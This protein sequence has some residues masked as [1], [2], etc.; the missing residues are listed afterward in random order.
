MNRTDCFTLH[1]FSNHFTK[2]D[3][4][5]FLAH[6]TTLYCRKHIQV[7]VS[8]L[9]WSKVDRSIQFAKTGLTGLTSLI[10]VTVSVQDTKVKICPF[11]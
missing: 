7:L 9:K 5:R 11:F 2:T 1:H 3:L 10:E 4:T 8:L 6:F